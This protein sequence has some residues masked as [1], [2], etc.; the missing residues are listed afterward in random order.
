MKTKMNLDVVAEN[1][2]ELLKNGIDIDE[3]LKEVFDNLLGDKNN[4][5]INVVCRAV[6]KMR[7]IKYKEILK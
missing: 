4:D 7:K 3:K 1:E 2:E 6:E 5:I